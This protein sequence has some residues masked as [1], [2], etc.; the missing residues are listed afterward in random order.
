MKPFLSEAAEDIYRSYGNRL[1][2]ICLV[3]PNRR[4]GIFFNKYLG[5]RLEQPVW[6]PAIYTIQ[7]LMA[8]ISDL[9]YA[10]DLELIS[11]L[12]TVYSKVRGK[13]E[14]FDESRHRINNNFDWSC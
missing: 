13:N 12:F 4:A 7:D 2:E 14:S 5:E 11:R 10:D 6:S 3:F 8:R 1:E 9:E